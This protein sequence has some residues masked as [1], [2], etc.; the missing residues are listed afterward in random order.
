MAFL[1]LA[2]ELVRR[3]ASC[4]PCYHNIYST[5]PLP[6]RSTAARRHASPPSAK[7]KRRPGTL[8]I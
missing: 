5:E 8:T 7:G 6:D 3:H 4:P 1:D 2:M